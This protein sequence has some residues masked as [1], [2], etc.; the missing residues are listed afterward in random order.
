M[1]AMREA[2]SDD[3]LDELNR[4]VD[5]GFRRVN[6][7]SRR[8]NEDLHALRI[9]TKT[10]IHEFRGE[11]NERFERLEA[12]LDTRFDGVH[13]MLVLLCGG[14]ITGLIGVIASILATGA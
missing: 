7:D 2:W 4:K 5:E 3:R 1:E 9:E 14:I 11:V 6:E 13:K 12:R 8:V 10:E